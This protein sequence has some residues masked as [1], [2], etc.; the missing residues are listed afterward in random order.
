MIEKNV[1]LLEKHTKTYIITNGKVLHKK[2]TGS[3][4][5]KLKT[6]HKKQDQ[7]VPTIV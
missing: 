5:I 3:Q 2:T 1:Y 6:V 7:Q 4:T